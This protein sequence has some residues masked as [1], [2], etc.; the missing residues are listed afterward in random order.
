MMVRI[1]LAVGIAA[2]VICGTPMA[3]AQ[4]V[5][6]GLTFTPTERQAVRSWLKR[7]RPTPV[8]ERLSVGAPLPI[9]V[10]SYP[11]PRDWGRSVARY[12]YVHAGKRVYF[13]EPTS[14]KIVLMVD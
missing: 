4:N 6:A 5:G 3:Q 2:F 8:K 14:G 10:E 12:R 1:G 7:Q 9:D 13:V 11:V